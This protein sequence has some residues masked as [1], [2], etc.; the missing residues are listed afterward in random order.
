MDTKSLRVFLHLSESLHFSR[1]SDA[2]H[3]SASTLSRHIK[4]IEE[5]LGQTLFIRDNRSVALTQDG[6]KFQRYARE[7]LAAWDVFKQSLGT[8]AEQLKGELSLYCSVTA[9]YSFLYSILSKFRVRYPQI[10]I[11]IHTGDPVPAIG[12]VQNKHED[13]SIAARPN[14]I[15]SVME[16][17]RIAISPLVFI[18]PNDDAVLHKLGVNQ[19]DMIDWQQVP[20]IVSE[21]GIGRT[22]IDQWFRHKGLKPSIYAQV[23]GNEA[24]VSMVSLG[25]GVGVVP[26]LVLDNSPLA[27]SVKVIDVHPELEPFDVGLF[28]LKK[29]LSNPIV[30]AFW[31]QI[32][33]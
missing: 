10:E 7:T 18:A 27:D 11:K 6:V 2:L 22:R 13:I 3:M 8:S 32:S 15:P 30:K 25:F 1:T 4:Q 29:S 17:K 28:T 19:L 31:D 14:S 24:I 33:V 9:S 16:F 12:R 26:Q 5:E 23:S 21:E 20:M